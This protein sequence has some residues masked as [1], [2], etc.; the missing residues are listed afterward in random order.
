MV[1]DYVV[2]NNYENLLDNVIKHRDSIISHLNWV[3]IFLG[4]HSF[5]IYIQCDMF[6]FKL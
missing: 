5:G 6:F 1:R 2:A 4:L 3:C